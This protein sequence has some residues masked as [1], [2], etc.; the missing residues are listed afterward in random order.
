MCTC[1]YIYIY[2]LIYIYIYTRVYNYICRVT[3]RHGSADS[4]NGGD[5]KPE[6]TRPLT[7]FDDLITYSYE[8]TSYYF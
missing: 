3:S 7:Y 6:A 8:L 4:Q 5:A 2:N 1:V